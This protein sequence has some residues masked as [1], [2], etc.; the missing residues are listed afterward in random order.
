M[1]LNSYHENYQHITSCAHPQSN[2]LIKWDKE[3]DMINYCSQ[4]ETHP[5]AVSVQKTPLKN[6]TS[7]KPEKEHVA[8]P[9][10]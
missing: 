5:V 7:V 6:N 8:G 4:A 9:K 1:C 3:Y 2:L 10:L